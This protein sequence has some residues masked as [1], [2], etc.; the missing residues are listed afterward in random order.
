LCAC[1]VLDELKGWLGSWLLRTGGEAGESSK[2]VCERERES[3]H[4][5]VVLCGKRQQR[6]KINREHRPPQTTTVST[7]QT[8]M[9]V[10]KKVRNRRSILLPLRPTL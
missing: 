8:L 1:F 7:A 6:Q 4:E 9:A 3:V 10:S 2:C 5:G